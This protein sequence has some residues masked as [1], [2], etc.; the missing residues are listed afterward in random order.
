[1]HEALKQ[2]PLTSAKHLS[3]AT[4]LSIPTVNTAL[5]ALERL[6]IVRE[7]TGQKRNRLFSYAEYLRLITEEGA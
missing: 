5:A 6:G 3:T 2:S 7:T 4:T 1:V